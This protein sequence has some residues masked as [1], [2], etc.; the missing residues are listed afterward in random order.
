MINYSKF[1]TLSDIYIFVQNLLDDH[2]EFEYSKLDHVDYP[3]EFHVNQISNWFEENKCEPDL[4]TLF[5][6]KD[7]QYV[8]YD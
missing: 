7:F 3:Y 1:K 5:Y 4:I 2:S 6:L 8:S